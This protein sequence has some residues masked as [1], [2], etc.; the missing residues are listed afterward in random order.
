MCTVP[1]R[2]CIDTIMQAMQSSMYEL[3][4]WWISR[5]AELKN[6]LTETLALFSASAHKSWLT[7]GSDL[8]R[9]AE[10]LLRRAAPRAGASSRAEKANVD[11]T[12]DVLIIDDSAAAVVGAAVG[13][14][15]A[16]RETSSRVG[17]DAG[18]SA[19]GG[20]SSGRGR[21]VGVGGGASTARETSSRATS[22]LDAQNAAVYSRREANGPADKRSDKEQR[23]SNPRPPSESSPRPPAS[24][25]KGWG[26]GG[27]SSGAEKEKRGR[28]RPRGSKNQ[29]KRGGRASTTAGN[30]GIQG[31]DSSR[32]QGMRNKGALG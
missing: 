30:P 25:G 15:S 24:V 26:G 7:F 3:K 2:L 20:S 1:A 14:A 29:N 6:N 27:S 16:A 12:N 19:G 32:R 11:A 21:G 10:K 5:K 17:E 13:G 4:R 9:A 31:A 23:E 8:D 18:P 28:G 22:R